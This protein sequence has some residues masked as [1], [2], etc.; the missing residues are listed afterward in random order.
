MRGR[1][2]SRHG[3][4]LLWAGAEKGLRGRKQ[5]ARPHVGV[6]SSLS[7]AESWAQ[8]GAAYEVGAAGDGLWR[9]AAAAAEEEPSPPGTCAARPPD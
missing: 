7:Q 5:E 1:H 3:T 4:C 6:Y 2:C 9:S 8:V